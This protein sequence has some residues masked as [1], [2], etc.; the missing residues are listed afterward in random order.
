MSLVNRPRAPELPNKS[1]AVVKVTD[2]AQLNALLDSVTSPTE[3]VLDSSSVFKGQIVV[4]DG[5]KN[6]IFRPSGDSVDVL[7]PIVGGLIIGHGCSDI[8]IQSIDF[9]LSDWVTPTQKVYIGVSMGRSVSTGNEATRVEDLPNRIYFKDV[10]VFGRGQQELRIG[11]CANARNLVLDGCGTYAVQEI[12]ADSQGVLVSNSPGPFH[13]KGCHFEAAGENMLFGE[14]IVRIP[15]IEI[16]DITIEGCEFL[17]PLEWKDS[18]WQIKNLLEFKAGVRASVSGCLFR[19]CWPAA[20]QGTSLLITPRYK[21]KTGDIA[22]YDNV[23]DNVYA[24]IQVAAGDDLDATGPST[25]PVEISSN[26]Y[27]NLGDG[28]VYRV[29]SPDLFRKIKSLWIEDERW[30]PLKSHAGVLVYE[31]AKSVESFGMVNCTGT[32]GRYGI[33][34]NGGSLGK[35]ALDAWNYTWIARGNVLFSLTDIPVNEFPDGIVCRK[36]V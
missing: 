3:F 22:I 23:F 4:P 12:G 13:F 15:G 26:F 33:F 24:G 5:K 16:G 28:Y 17:K 30:Y 21:N 11:F 29:T 31:G 19:N 8:T 35:A 1:H 20:Q 27:T 25:G 18:R 36:A 6:L 32:R 34:G 9:H 10:N 2:V 14:G 7:Y